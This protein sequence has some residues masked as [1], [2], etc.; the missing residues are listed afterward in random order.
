MTA[1]NLTRVFKL[2]ITLLPDPDPTLSPEAALKLYESAYPL[3][4]GATLGEPEVDGERLVFPVNRRAVQTKGVD[5]M[6]EATGSLL[7]APDGRIT[8]LLTAIFGFFGLEGDEG[9]SPGDGYVHCDPSSSVLIEDVFESLREWAIEN[10]LDAPDDDA[11]VIQAIASHLGR[12]LGDVAAAG[13]ACPDQDRSDDMQIGN[14]VE[15]AKALDDGHGLVGL[16]LQGAHYAGKPVLDGYGGYALSIGQHTHFSM[17]TGDFIH[18][19]SDIEQTLASGAPDRLEQAARILAK[20]VESLLHGIAAPLR[21][22]LAR[23][24]ADPTLLI[25]AQ[26]AAHG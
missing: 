10:G 23:L 18:F 12:P 5:Y 21:A 4:A 2:G 26:G 14:A 7:F 19:A 13:L 16:R 3:C 6:T 8:R 20:H 22:P 24:I 25:Q 11:G 17:D 15:L 9:D 1:S